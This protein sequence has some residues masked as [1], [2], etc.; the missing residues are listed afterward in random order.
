MEAQ[1]TLV[2]E[3]LRYIDYQVT[4]PAGNSLLV[5]AYNGG[6]ILPDAYGRNK[7]GHIYAA[8]I[9][10]QYKAEQAVRAAL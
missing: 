1:V 5:R 6:T 2:H 9:S 3:Y 10:E 4:F 7:D 8:P